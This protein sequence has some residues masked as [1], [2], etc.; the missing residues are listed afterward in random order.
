M[1]YYFI[2]TTPSYLLIINPVFSG[3]TKVIAIA[4]CGPDQSTHFNRRK[5]SGYKCHNHLLLIFLYCQLYYARDIAFTDKTN[6]TKRYNRKKRRI[7]GKLRN[8]ETK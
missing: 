2:T 7:E 1:H 5:D 3:K 4:V 8:T 6:V